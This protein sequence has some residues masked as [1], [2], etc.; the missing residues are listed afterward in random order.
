MKIKRNGFFNHGLSPCIWCIQQLYENLA[1]YLK[2]SRGAI[3]LNTVTGFRN[4]Q[5]WKLTRKGILLLVF[6]Q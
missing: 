1:N 4:L 3:L 5:G 6:R 2:N